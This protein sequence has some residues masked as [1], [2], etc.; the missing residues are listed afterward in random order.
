[1]ETMDGVRVSFRRVPRMKHLGVTESRAG[2]AREGRSGAGQGMRGIQGQTGR[3][4]VYFALLRFLLNCK[5]RVH[6]M[7]SCVRGGLVCLLACLLASKQKA[8]HDPSPQVRLALVSASWSAER[9]SSRAGNLKRRGGS[10]GSGSCR[11]LQIPF[12]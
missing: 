3:Q 6:A 10:R 8:E 5:S 1:M 7:H 11:A 4:T 2:R 9:A 12:V